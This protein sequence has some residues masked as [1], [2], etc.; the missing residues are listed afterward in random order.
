MLKTAPRMEVKMSSGILYTS[1][2]KE[3]TTIKDTR[4]TGHHVHD[5]NI[6]GKRIGGGRMN[7]ISST[8][9]GIFMPE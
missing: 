1:G 3:A 6:T 5:R 2:E 9:D 7:F 8:P 4:K